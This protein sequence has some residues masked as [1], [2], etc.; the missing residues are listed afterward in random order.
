MARAVAHYVV[1]A[2]LAL[3]STQ[4]AV[5]SVRLKPAGEIIWC[6]ESERQTFIERVT[7]DGRERR[8]VRESPYES[9]ILPPPDSAALFQRPPPVSFFFS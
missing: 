7:R 4:A 5:P 8:V 6:S 1:A 3:L 9:R 2:L